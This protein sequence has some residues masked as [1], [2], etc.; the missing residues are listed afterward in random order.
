MELINSQ[1]ITLIRG[2]NEQNLK[3][4][5]RVVVLYKSPGHTSCPIRSYRSARR[6]EGYF[7]PTS[8]WTK[9]GSVRDYSPG[10]NL[11]AVYLCE[12]KR[13]PAALY[14]SRP[15]LTPSPPLPYSTCGGL[16]LSDWLWSTK[17]QQKTCIDFERIYSLGMRAQRAQILRAISKQY[18]SVLG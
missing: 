10:C 16:C 6:D 9:P 11:K 15:A 12:N 4:N 2:L 13:F 8:W 5:E 14:P 3:F 7:S 17:N 18:W 1:E